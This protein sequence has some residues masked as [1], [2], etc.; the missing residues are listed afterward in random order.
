MLHEILCSLTCNVQERKIAALLIQERKIVA[1]LLLVS[2]LLSG[3]GCRVNITSFCIIALLSSSITF[4]FSS[5]ASPLCPLAFWIG[6]LFHV[7]TRSLI[8]FSTT[9][10]LL[11]RISATVNV[12]PLWVWLRF[13]VARLP[14]ETTIFP[15]SQP[16]HVLLLHFTE[17]CCCIWCVDGVAADPLQA[18]GSWCHCRKHLEPLIYVQKAEN[19]GYITE[20]SIFAP[21][22]VIAN[23]IIWSDMLLE[24][25]ILK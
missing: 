1:L 11:L 10:P 3:L 6:R 21:N 15:I 25:F 24:M 22:D 16:S 14:S 2:S 12:W 13:L 20:S 8:F 19:G 4:S 5:Y 17:P 9:N 18:W 7:N 23:I